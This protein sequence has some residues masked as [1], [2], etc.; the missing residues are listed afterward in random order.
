MPKIKKDTIVHIKNYDT[1]KVFQFDNS[2]K[3]YVSFYVG[4]SHLHKSG[5]IEKSTK[6]SNQREAI[7]VAKQI[8]DEFRVEK[9]DEIVNKDYNLDKDIV[10]SYFY[11][12]EKLYQ[13]RNRNVSNM[14]KEKNQY[15]NYCSPFF[16]NVNYNDEI[17]VENEIVN[18]VDEVVTTPVEV[19]VQTGVATQ[20]A[21]RTSK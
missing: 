9:K 19:S 10:E 7:K 16:A 1:L 14:T 13:M 3:Y 11:S 12:R 21:T 15:Y 20:T 18:V 5:N 4:K 17:E 6:Q 8:Y 2:K